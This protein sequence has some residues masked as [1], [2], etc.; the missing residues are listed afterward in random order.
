[1]GL[2]K[3]LVCTSLHKTSALIFLLHATATFGAPRFPVSTKV[4]LNEIKKNR[5]GCLIHALFVHWSLSNYIFMLIRR[6]MIFQKM[7]TVLVLG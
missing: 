7:E 3:R 4:N 6:Y 1:M 2:D 5:V